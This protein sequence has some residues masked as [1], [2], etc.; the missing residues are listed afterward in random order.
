MNLREELNKLDH[1][2]LENDERFYD[3]RSLLEATKLTPQQKDQLHQAIN[4]GDSEEAFRILTEPEEKIV[5]VNNQ[6]DNNTQTNSQNNTLP[7]STTNLQNARN[8]QNMGANVEAGS[9]YGNERKPLV[10]SMQQEIKQSLSEDVEED[11]DEEDV[12]EPSDECKD[13][14]D[15]FEAFTD[16]LDKVCGNCKN[17]IIEEA[18][19]GELEASCVSEL[20]Y[21]TPC[22]TKGDEIIC[23]GFEPVD[24]VTEIENEEPL[25]EGRHDLRPVRCVSEKSKSTYWSP[26]DSKEKKFAKF[27]IRY[28]YD[29][30]EK[31]KDAIN[32][33]KK[34]LGY[35]QE[36]DRMYEGKRIRNRLTL[37]EELF[38]EE[39]DKAEINFNGTVVP[40]DEIAPQIL[41]MINSP[42]KANG[43][44]KTETWLLIKL[45][46]NTIA[47][48]APCIDRKDLVALAGTAMSGRAGQSSTF[49]NNFKAVDL[50]YLNQGMV[51]PGKNLEDWFHGRATLVIPSGRPNGGRNYAGGV[52]LRPFLNKSATAKVAQGAKPM[53]S[54][55]VRGFMPNS[56]S[57]STSGGN[58]MK[59]TNTAPSSE[60]PT[61]VTATLDMF[62][63]VGN[64]INKEAK[65]EVPKHVVDRVNKIRSA[66]RKTAELEEDCEITEDMIDDFKFRKMCADNGWNFEKTRKSLLRKDV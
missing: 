8:A 5:V 29:T 61:Y 35:K 60:E 32:D 37:S 55:R 64:Q 12:E 43:E 11:T 21:E 27:G 63:S 66:Y 44:P 25:E 28:R 39:S 31:C 18:E 3:L 16:G 15:Y 53:R 49:F 42:L 52:D 41:S 30:K 26:Y 9:D 13:I 56:K 33:P 2:A 57:N 65:K 14:A 54:S 47:V 48:G 19:D 6:Q 38:M 36:D 20:D 50:A 1:K 62:E 22:E 7:T 4:K 10:A 51:Y 23:P 46:E 40:E 34:D 59:T 58:S 24:N 45:Y 17:C